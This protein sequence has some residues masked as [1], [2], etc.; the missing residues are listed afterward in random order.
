MEEAKLDPSKI[1]EFIHKDFDENA[2][3]CLQGTSCTLPLSAFLQ[4]LPNISSPI[5][6]Q[7]TSKPHL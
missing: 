2:L 5:K 1:K 6:K 4:K 3:P 7:I